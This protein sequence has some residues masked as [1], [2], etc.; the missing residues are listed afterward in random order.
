MGFCNAQGALAFVSRAD[1]ECVVAAISKRA[2]CFGSGIA[3]L[4]T[5]LE[6]KLTRSFISWVIFKDYKLLDTWS[7]SLIWTLG[8]GC[9][10]LGF[11][12]IEIFDFIF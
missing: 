12:A 1:L 7:R 10:R 8:R 6:A 4:P 9:G 11:E 3:G 2:L 5:G